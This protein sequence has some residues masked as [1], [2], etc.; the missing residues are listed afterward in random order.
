[1][2]SE[3][4]NKIFLIKWSTVA[5]IITIKRNGFFVA[6]F[7]GYRLAEMYNQHYGYGCYI[8]CTFIL[9]IMYYTVLFL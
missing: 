9:D 6:A 8:F 1:M 5:H 2:K 7:Q 4:E 3:Q